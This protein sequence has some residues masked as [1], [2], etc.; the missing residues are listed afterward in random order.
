MLKF[1]IQIKKGL[2]F[3]D[4]L[5]QLTRDVEETE[6]AAMQA[7]VDASRYAAEA[8]RSAVSEDLKRKIFSG[9]E[10]INWSESK[11]YAVGGV[12]LAEWQTAV[13]LLRPAY[14]TWIG[15][16]FVDQPKRYQIFLSMCG[17]TEAASIMGAG[18]NLHSFESR[19]FDPA[20][21]A[22]A[23]RRDT[24]QDMLNQCHAGKHVYPWICAHP[25][26]WVHFNDDTWQQLDI[27]A[28]DWRE[29]ADGIRAQRE[30]LNHGLS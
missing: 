9:D 20:E 17:V 16:W 23:H 27:D 6:D 13:N 3:R 11:T 5:S 22:I 19:L 1:D 4:I 29:I 10:P 12:T 21:E 30:Q 15:I 28:A 26:V 24:F 7:A 25:G 2:A 18:P 14:P 8:F